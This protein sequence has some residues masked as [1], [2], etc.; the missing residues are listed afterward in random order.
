MNQYRVVLEMKPD[1]VKGPEAIARLY[2][3]TS[4]GALVPVPAITKQK[5]GNTALSINHQG[6]FPATTIS[7]NLAPG[8]SLS[9]AVAAVHRAEA[10]IGMP[11]AVHADFQGTAQ[12][13]KSS[14]ESQPLLI[15]AALV[16][17]YIVLGMLY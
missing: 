14:L 12:A 5:T 17:V 9:D 16:T 13:F 11:A 1:L 15:L 6:Q 7:F 2:L 10:D 3:R 8:V 4:S